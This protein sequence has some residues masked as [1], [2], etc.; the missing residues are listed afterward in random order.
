MQPTFIHS[1]Y[2]TFLPLYCRPALWTSAGSEFTSDDSSSDWQQSR[3]V[4]AIRPV[5]SAVPFGFRI[6]NR[7]EATSKTVCNESTGNNDT[8]YRKTGQRPGVNYHPPQFP[9]SS[10]CLEIKNTH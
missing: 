3:R 9:Q 10:M 8:R 7:F 2:F 5:R 6:P 1:E 4:Q